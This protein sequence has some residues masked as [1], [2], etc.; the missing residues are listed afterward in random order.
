MA[1]TEKQLLKVWDLATASK[2]LELSEDE[3]EVFTQALKKRN[4][5]P[6]YGSAPAVRSDSLGEGVQGI[7]N[8]ADGK[9]YD[10][11]SS[12]EKAVKAKGCHVVGNDWNKAEYKTPAER[13]IKGNFDSRREL[14]E[15]VQKVV[16]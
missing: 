1:R 4:K 5:W 12:F 14:K 2:P 13:G 8:H 7:I 3:T 16:G 10:S 15:A 6:L 9:L 11:K